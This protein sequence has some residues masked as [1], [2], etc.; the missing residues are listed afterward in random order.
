VRG[1]AW[2]VFSLSRVEPCAA[3]EVAGTRPKA[4]SDVATHK[5]ERR[6][7]VKD[8]KRRNI[9]QENNKTKYMDMRFYFVL[10]FRLKSDAPAV[11]GLN[12]L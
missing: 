11:L 8:L 4:K 1:P 6:V 9:E 3:A 12:F 7:I 10:F 5:I 2:A